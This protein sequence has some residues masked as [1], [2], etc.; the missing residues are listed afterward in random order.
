M[1]RIVSLMIIALTTLSMAAQDPALFDTTWFIHKITF[2]GLETP[3][4]QSSEPIP[5][6][7]TRFI[8][9]TFISMETRHCNLYV[10][11]IEYIISDE[12]LIQ[13]VVELKDTCLE[14]ANLDFTSLLANVITV[15]FSPSGE[16][17]EYE[18]TSSGSSKSL[19]ITNR[20]GDSV[21]YGNEMLSVSDNTALPVIIYPNPTNNLLMLD[22]TGEAISEVT[23]ISVAG[24]EV[25]SFSEIKTNNTVDVSNLPAGVYF[26]QVVAKTGQRQIVRFVKK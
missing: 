25:A 18:I 22:I 16:I 7:E 5:F 21:L 4:P 15:D 11:N 8:D 26:I 6:E 24:I 19:L 17:F 20:L 12:F 23:I 14:Q 10:A 2:N 1:K 13:G 9:D 3:I